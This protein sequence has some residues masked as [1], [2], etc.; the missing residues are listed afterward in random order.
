MNTKIII[1]L[2]VVLCGAVSSVRAEEL[3]CR[4]Y[5]EGGNCIEWAPKTQPVRYEWRTVCSGYTEGG[6]CI[7]PHRVLTPVYGHETQPD[8]CPGGYTE[9]GQ[10]LPR[11]N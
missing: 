10:C 4:N 5:T 3:E 7:D 9:G 8:P 2:G 6:A 1:A 11:W